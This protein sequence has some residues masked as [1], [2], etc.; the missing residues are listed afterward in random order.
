MK[1]IALLVA[2]CFLTGNA[3]AL[4][5]PQM[6]SFSQ[7]AIST[8]L[9]PVA[10]FEGGQRFS[11]GDYPVIVLS[12]TY[13]QMGRQYGGL[14]KNEL[15]EEYTFLLDTLAKRGYTQEE[16]REYGREIPAFYPQRVKEIFW[17]MSET[18]GPDT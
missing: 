6:V 16:I 15:N 3:A 10:S 9:T 18:S 11:A 14:M 2:L 4:S 12:G 17:G 7:P 1:L 8:D 13:R 5:L